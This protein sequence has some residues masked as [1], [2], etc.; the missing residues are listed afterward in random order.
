MNEVSEL[1]LELRSHVQKLDEI[2]L[3]NRLFKVIDGYFKDKIIVK[4]RSK[5]NERKKQKGV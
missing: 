2:K 4:L 1:K 3:L 5:Q